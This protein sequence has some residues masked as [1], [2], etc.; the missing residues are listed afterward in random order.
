MA[1]SVVAACVILVAAAFPAGAAEPRAAFD[2]PLPRGN[3]FQTGVAADAIPD[4][5]APR[6]KFACKNSIDTAPVIVGDIVLVASKDE[7]LYALNLADGK[8]RWK[9]RA[10]QFNAPPAVSE[11][12]IYIGDADGKFHCIELATGKGRWTCDLEIAISS[13]ANFSGDSV[14]FGSED[15]LHCLSRAGKPRWRFK[16]PGGPVL[17]SPAVAGDVA[18]ASGCDKVLHVI[19]VTT[20][21]ELSAIPLEGQ[22]AGAVAV[23]GD[24]LFVGTMNGD[25]LGIDWKKPEVFW[26]YKAG[27]AFF[28]STCLTPKH[29]VLGSRDK[30]IHAIDRLTGKNAWTFETRGKVDGSA[31][32][33]GTRIHVASLDGN[34][35]LL[36][37]DKGKQVK[38]VKLDSPAFGS[39]AVGGGCLVIS[40]LRGVTHCFGAK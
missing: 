38:N 14:L 29:V 16:I 33:A 31:V 21:K 39:P 15:T 24:R 32:L 1:R 7:F 12:L 30:K 6:W 22:A 35:Y 5:M 37:A 10:A 8:E 20:G 23:D 28:A 40:T 13:G 25:A 19:N 9:Y 17:A 26:R 36:D 11:G 3:G 2:W 27:Q 18:F 34:L 4:D